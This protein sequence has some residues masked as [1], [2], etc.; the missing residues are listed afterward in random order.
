MLADRPSREAEDLDGPDRPANVIRMQPRRRDRVH[1][2]KLRTQRRRLHRP[3]FLP[4]RLIRTRPLE[5]PI[6]QQLYIQ[7]R[8]TH[9]DRDDLPPAALRDHSLRPPQPLRRCESLAWPH[10]IDEMVDDAAPLLDGRLCR[11]NVH[12][13]IDLEG[14]G[15][16]DLGRL[17]PSDQGPRERDREARLASCRR[18]HDDRRLLH[19]GGLSLSAPRRRHGS[20]NLEPTL[21]PC[22]FLASRS[23]AGQTSAKAPS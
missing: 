10:Q 11:A 19:F 8:A 17:A 1:A 6:Q 3:Q 18:T 5:H 14:I 2:L 20:A 12:A 15:R 21:S 13:A 16:H 4:Q 23:S 22:P 9:H 7:V